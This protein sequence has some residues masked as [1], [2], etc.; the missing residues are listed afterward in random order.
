MKE[1]SIFGWFILCIQNWLALTLKAFF[2]QRHLLYVRLLCKV[3]CIDIFNFLNRPTFILQL[4]LSVIFS[5]GKL[6]Y[7]LFHTFTYYHWTCKFQIA[8]YL[9]PPSMCGCSDSKILWWSCRRSTVHRHKQ[10]IYT[11]QTKR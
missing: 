4:S 9:Q 10:W 2:V 7:L 11:S 1:T 5:Y 6:Y 3:L 8:F